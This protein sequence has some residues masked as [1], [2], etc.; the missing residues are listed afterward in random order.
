[1]YLSPSQNAT[2]NPEKLRSLIIEIE[3]I[4]EGYTGLDGEYHSPWTRDRLI[5][6]MS[7]VSNI[8]DGIARQNKIYDSRTTEKY[9]GFGAQIREKITIARHKVKAAVCGVAKKLRLDREK[10]GSGCVS[11]PF[12][13]NCFDFLESQGLLTRKWRDYKGPIYDEDGGIHWDICATFQGCNVAELLCVFK[14]AWNVF[15][16]RQRRIEDDLIST[17]RTKRHNARIA[18][19]MALPSHY[20]MSVQKLYEATFGVTL[21]QS[22]DNWVEEPGEDT[23]AVVHRERCDRLHAKQRQISAH[24]DQ[25]LNIGA[26]VADALWDE[27]RRIDLSIKGSFVVENIA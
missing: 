4:F 12:V 8:I 3:Q 23:G 15:H 14:A 26:E 17:D 19:P 6:M 9:L 11:E 13:R 18:K 20:F 22:I 25:L 7:V 1:M 24:I 16:A 27:L 5:G 10:G 21:N 2:P